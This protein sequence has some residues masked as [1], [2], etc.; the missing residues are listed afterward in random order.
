MRRS[1]SAAL[2][3]SFLATIAVVGAAGGGAIVAAHEP[4][5]V[6]IA[7]DDFY[8]SE[9]MAEIYAQA[10]TAA[11]FTVERQYRLGSR[12]VRAAAFESGQVDLV[13]EYVGS[14]LGH[15]ADAEGQLEAVAALEVTTDGE[16]NRANLQAA[17]DLLGIEATVLGITPGEDKNVAVVRRQTAEEL[18]LDSLSDVAAVQDQLRFG[19]PPE[20]DINP[21]CAGALE[22]YGI[23]YP[24]RQRETLPPCSGPMVDALVGEAID[25]GWLCSTQPPI[26]L[27]DFVVLADEL[28][29]QGAENVAPVVRD[30]FLAGVDGGADTIAGILDPV[31]AAIT[32]EVLFD[33]G[34]RIAV[35]QVD[36]EDVAADFLASLEATS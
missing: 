12:A 25:L 27:D 5:T 26:V 1:R 16:V 32:T 8:E 11:G 36:I 29:T 2:G 19:L 23:T 4:P 10:L 35:D 31:S 33:L 6:R 17:Y 24:P 7:S 3:A 20:C 9:L 15:Y 34:L 30:D 28:D 13:P 21:F 14:G 18:G 22:A